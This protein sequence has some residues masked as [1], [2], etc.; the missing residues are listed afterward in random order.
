M[1]AVNNVLNSGDVP[2][3]YRVEDMD[4]IGEV[5]RPIC[6][7]LG[8]MPT[9]ANVFTAYLSRVKKNIHVTLAFSPVGDDFRDRMRMFPSLVN[10]CTIDWS[11][12]RAGGQPFGS[13]SE[14][15]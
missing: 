10:C 13:V 14:K 9:K 6:A 8:L 4:V 3:L 12:E 1:E 11:R 5:G 7:Q 15:F 2:N